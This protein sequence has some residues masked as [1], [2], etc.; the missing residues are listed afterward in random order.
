MVQWSRE[1]LE[2]LVRQSGTNAAVKLDLAITYLQLGKLQASS[3]GGDP[4]PW[5]EAIASYDRG[6]LLLE[7]VLAREP[8]SR[9]AMLG[10]AHLLEARSEAEK[11]LGRL[12]DS[13][14]D[15]DLAR[16][17]LVRNE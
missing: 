1:T 3:G 13:A 16:Q 15:A 7:P 6:L 14:R 9:Q 2:N 8:G 11:A 5:T 17:I 10:K 12:E 4:L